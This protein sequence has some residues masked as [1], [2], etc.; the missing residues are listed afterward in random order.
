MTSRAASRASADPTRMK[1]ISS[2]ARLALGLWPLV[3]IAADCLHQCIDLAVEEMIGARDHLLLDHDALLRLE[4]LDEDADVLVR[5]H[6]ILI[7]M[8]DHAGGWAWREERKIVEIGWRR[9]R[10]EAL[11]LRPA[12]EQLHPD[13][14]AE[15]EAGNPAAPGFWVDRLCPV[16]RRSRIRQLAL[17]VIEC[18]LAA[19]HP[20]EVEAQ[21]GKVPVHERVVHLVDDLVVHRAPELGMRMQ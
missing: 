12:H 13:P 10:D 9:D 1:M 19:P 2:G 7:A 15:G 14:G 18:A 16:E 4:L 5:H 21:H 11:D 3:E 17:A 6:C 8:N 20:A